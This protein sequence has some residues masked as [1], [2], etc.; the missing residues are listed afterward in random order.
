M[1]WFLHFCVFL[2][3]DFLFKMPPP[4]CRAEVLSGVPK[5]LK[6]KM[7]QIQKLCSGVNVSDNAVGH[8]FD[9]NESTNVLDKESL[10]KTWLCEQLIQ[11][12]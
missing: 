9:V 11:R 10:K 6:E 5:C 7:H 3:G 1:P 12:L 4:E 8:E 2:V